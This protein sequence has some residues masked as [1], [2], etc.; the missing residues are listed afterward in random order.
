MTESPAPQQGQHKIL[1]LVQGSMA[2]SL[3]QPSCVHEMVNYY[4]NSNIVHTHACMHVHTHAHIPLTHD[5][6]DTHTYTDRHT[7]TH[8][9]TCTHMHT[10]HS[11][12]H[13]DTDRQTHTHTHLALCCT[14]GDTAMKFLGFANLNIIDSTRNYKHTSY[15]GME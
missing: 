1:I 7:Y 6:T 9:R 10:Y 13:T 5:T 11:H 12:T 4:H 8:V 3:G 2:D 15:T 14:L